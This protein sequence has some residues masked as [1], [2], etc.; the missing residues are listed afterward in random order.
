MTKGRSLG[1]LEQLVLLA[2]L[3]LDGNAYGMRIRREIEGRCGRDVAIGA[4][5]SALDRMERKGYIASSIGSPSPTPGGRAR[6]LFSVREE[7]LNAL[8]TS[9][10]QIRGL[11]DGLD[12]DL[13]L[14]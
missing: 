12:P 6:R 10:H 11:L 4:V 5:Y 9:L 8:R 14:G 1:E 13:E 7:G 2:V 3:H